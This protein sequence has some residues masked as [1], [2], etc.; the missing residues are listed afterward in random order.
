MQNTV[1]IGLLIALVAVSGCIWPPEP[2]ESNENNIPLSPPKYPALTSE[3]TAKYCD[4][5]ANRGGPCVDF[6]SKNTCLEELCDALMFEVEGCTECSPGCCS[7]C[8]NLDSCESTKAC[9]I[10]WI[11]PS[12]ESW[13]F[14]GCEN[15]NLC[16]GKEEECNDKFVS[17]QGYRYSS[18]IEEDQTKAAEYSQKSDELQ[19]AYNAECE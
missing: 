6:C 16:A 2:P 19:D 10:A 13:Q 3:P 18:L 12:G 1:W 15:A 8:T 5:P 11:H 4:T 17:F 7:L 14:G 9:R